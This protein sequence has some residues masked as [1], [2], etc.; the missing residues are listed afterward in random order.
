MRE[1]RRKFALMQSEAEAVQ[2]R[3]VKRS[4][5]TIEGEAKRR[6]PVDRGPLR[7]SLTHET[8]VNGRSGR[9]GTNLEYAPAVELG[10]K[11]HMPPIE[12]LKDWA[13]RHGMPEEAGVV[14]AFKI[15]REGTKPKPFL[16][17]AFEAERPEFVARLRENTR[18]AIHR[19]ARS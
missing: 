5:V 18:R 1:L 17:P 7:T 12:P 11:P 14:I 6:A 19:V 2:R 13:R 8:S 3:D 9:A 10:S 16:F 4:L 15:A